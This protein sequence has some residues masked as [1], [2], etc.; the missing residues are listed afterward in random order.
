M[1]TITIDDKI[2]KKLFGLLGGEKLS[3]A[4]NLELY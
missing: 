3:V 4:A 1:G 2:D